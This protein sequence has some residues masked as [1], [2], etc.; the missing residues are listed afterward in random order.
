VALEPQTTLD[1][2]FIA[3]PAMKSAQ[4][5]CTATRRVR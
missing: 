3:E 1:S 2:E 4:I 5:I